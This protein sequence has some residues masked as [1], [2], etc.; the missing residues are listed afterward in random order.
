MNLS[1]AVGR[2]VRTGAVVGGFGALALALGAAIPAIGLTAATFGISSALGSGT[3]LAGFLSAAGSFA[4]GA[5]VGGAAGGTTFG[6]TH[7]AAEITG[8]NRLFGN[9]A[10]AVTQYQPNKKVGR[11]ASASRNVALDETDYR[12]VGFRRQIEEQRQQEELFEYEGIGR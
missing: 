7:I 3:M 8:I 4:V 9:T 10:P 6:V 2:G 12:N 1:W 5:V 11:S